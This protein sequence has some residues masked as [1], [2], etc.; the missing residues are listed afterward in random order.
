MHLIVVSRDLQQFQHVH[1]LPTGAPGEFAVDVVFPA[2][3]SYLLYD[4]FTRANGQD[5]VQRDEL[6]VGTASSGGASLAVDDAPKVRDRVRVALQGAGSVKAGASTRLTFRLDDAMTGAGIQDLQPYLGA[7]A[8]VVILSE[9]A[10]TFAHTHGEQVG[11]PSGQMHHG[12]AAT[13][14]GYGPE[15]AFEYTFPMPGLYKLWGQLQT[16]DGQVITAD[17]VVR[18]Q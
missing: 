7:P 10:Q 8:H 18:A 2:A 13:A 1:P 15:I 4:E 11:S 9:D 5:I 16:H 14:S 6:V 3:G 12:G 17:F